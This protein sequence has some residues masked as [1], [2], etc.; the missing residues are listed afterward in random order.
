MM[1]FLDWAPHWVLCSER[2]PPLIHSHDGSL[3]TTGRR[4]GDPVLVLLP[5]GTW[6]DEGHVGPPIRVLICSMKGEEDWGA[7]PVNTYFWY[8]GSDLYSIHGSTDRRY[9]GS[10]IMWA[11]LPKETP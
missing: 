7:V 9:S 3:M 1:N 8:D 10:P 4:W 11:E 2:M 6:A 5:A